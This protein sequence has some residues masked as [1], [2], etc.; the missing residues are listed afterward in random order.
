[1]DEKQAG[2]ELQKFASKL[3]L[4]QFRTRLA[5]GNVLEVLKSEGIDA[6]QLPKA[7]VEGLATLSVD[8]L[9]TLAIVNLKLKPD[10]SKAGGVEGGIL[11]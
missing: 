7:F 3:R 11:F 4:S 2:G 1:V 6:K 9:D 10:L 5:S 8:E